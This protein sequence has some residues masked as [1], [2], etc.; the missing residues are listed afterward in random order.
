MILINFAN[1][2]GFIIFSKTISQL[3]LFVKNFQKDLNLFFMTN[4]ELF[5]LIFAVSF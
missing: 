3:D 5:F 2:L 1:H 4:Q